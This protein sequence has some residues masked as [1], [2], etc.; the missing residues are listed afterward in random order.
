LTTSRQHGGPALLA[1]PIG[2]GSYRVNGVIPWVTGAD[3]AIAILAGAT[4]A[5]GAQILFMLAPEMPGVTID[6]PMILAALAG[7]R[8]AQIRCD[9]VVIPAH[10]IVAGPMPQVLGPVGGG[11]LETSCLALGIGRG[12]LEL[13]KSEAKRRPEVEA[14][15]AVFEADLTALRDRLHDIARTAVTDPERTLSLRTDATLFAL[16]VTQMALLLAKGTGF[17]APHPAQRFAR[18]AHFLLVWSCPRTVADGVK[19]GLMNLKQP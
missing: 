18:Q 16:R 6:A 8:T 7:S 2:D 19:A 4:Q 9:N 10:E 12:A 11:G 1:Q 5:D 17:V 15:V 13:I 14:T 3:R